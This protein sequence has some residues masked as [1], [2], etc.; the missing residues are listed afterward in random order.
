MFRKIAV[1]LVAATMLAA[2]VIADVTPAA[3]A[4]VKT[5]TT[6][7][8]KRVVHVKRIRH[9]RVIRHRAGVK[10]VTVVRQGHRWNHQVRR[11]TVVRKGPRVSYVR[12]A[13]VVRHGPRHVK[14][15]TVVRLSRRGHSGHVTVVR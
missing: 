4:A 8:T 14:R 7:R 15:V 3:A 13:T 12:R 9:V 2:P 6:V 11:V 1:A 10:H 5:T